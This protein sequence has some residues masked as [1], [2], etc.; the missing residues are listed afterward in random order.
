LDTSTHRP[1]RGLRKFGCLPRAFL[2]GLIAMCGAI[3]LMSRW[4][5]I[6]GGSKAGSIILVVIGTLLMLPLILLLIGAVVL[7]YFLGR[8]GKELDQS[9]KVM[10]DNAKAMYDRIHDFRPATDEDFTKVDRDAYEQTTRDFADAGFR[11]LGDL[12][13]QTIEQ[14]GQTGP[15]MRIMSSADGTT[16]AALY[17]FNHPNVPPSQDAPATLIC[18]LTSEFS[19]GT[20]LVTSNT[21]ELDQLTA[22]P[23]IQR[24]QLP[25]ET[26]TQMHR[27]RH[28]TEKQKLLAA[29][30]GATCIAVSTLDDAIEMAKR[31]QAIKNEYRK[32]IG[33]LDPAEVRRI[34]SKVAD[35]DREPDDE[36]AKE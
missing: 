26:A 23:R 12:V 6:G 36:A 21:E 24:R 17:H 28:E 33:Y 7:R 5:S 30:I 34:A 10:L 13:D 31:Q 25:L 35:E 3:W 20:F 2:T 15:P 14:L 29:K 18:D 22:P 1:F 9:T 19:D 32:S 11:Q 8:L 4:N 16:V 27:A